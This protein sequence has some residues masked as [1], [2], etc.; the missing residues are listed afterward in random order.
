MQVVEAIGSSLF[1][2]CTMTVD[3]SAPEGDITSMLAWVKAEED[4]DVTVQDS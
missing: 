1:Y 4:N 2:T 3:G